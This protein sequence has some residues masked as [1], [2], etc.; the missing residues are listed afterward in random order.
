MAKDVLYLI[1]AVRRTFNEEFQKTT[2]KKRNKIE[3]MFRASNSYWFERT[4]INDDQDEPDEISKPIVKARFDL[5]VR[6][7]RVGT[8]FWRNDRR[9][10]RKRIGTVNDDSLAGLHHK[11][12]DGRAIISTYEGFKVPGSSPI[13]PQMLS[14]NCPLRFVILSL[15]SNPIHYTR[16]LQ[17]WT[18]VLG[19]LPIV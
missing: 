16:V 7:D 2:R 3:K 11:R 10:G 13:P 6:V 18:R 15:E 4:R 17:R 9:K 5:S 8:K 12:N 1:L 14:R 19:S